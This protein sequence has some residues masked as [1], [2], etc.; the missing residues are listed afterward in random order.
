MKATMSS[1]VA[2]WLLTEPPVRFQPSA[3]WPLVVGWS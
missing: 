1:S 2:K 3:P